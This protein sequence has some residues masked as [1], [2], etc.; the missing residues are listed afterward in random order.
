VTAA[1]DVDV[2]IVGG[3]LAGTLAALALV[4]A[5]GGCRRI[6]VIDH[7]PDP[8][9]GRYWAY[10]SRNAIEPAAEI[11]AWQCVRIRSHTADQ[12]LPLQHYQ[13]RRISG[14]LLA[15]R[16]RDVAA[17]TDGRL[18]SVTDRVTGLFPSADT[19]RVRLAN[20]SLRASWVLDSAFGLPVMPGGPWLSFHGVR[21]AVPAALQDPVLMDF[22][23]RQADGIRFGYVLPE[24][25]DTLFAEATSFRSS[26]PDSG[27][28]EALQDWL[29]A[30]WP[31]H[32]R[33]GP[34][35]ERAA[36]PLHRRT[37]QR[38]HGRILRIG[39]VGGRTRRATGYGVLHYQQDAMAVAASLARTGRPGPLPAF[40]RRERWFDDVA[41]R[42]LA[43]DPAALRTGYEHLFQCNTGDDVLG[44]M[45]GEATARQTAA[46]VASMPIRP[47]LRAALAG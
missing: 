25:P 12:L 30:N 24:G 23:L 41:M 1:P 46:I 32:R 4:Q 17:A 33:I 35:I 14:N 31:F 26:G 38:E 18:T 11:A 6:A 5:A 10:F 29:C 2:A 19:V 16:L 37:R 42:V 27:L 28:A 47:F 3:G 44:F 43:R 36:L 9:A 40:S 21:I 8:L 45:A 39:R 34:V 22:T 7:S 20:G 15:A 13:Y